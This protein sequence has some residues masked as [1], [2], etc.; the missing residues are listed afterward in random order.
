MAGLF[1]FSISEL[2]DVLIEHRFQRTNMADEGVVGI[3]VNDA[4]A[5]AWG[6]AKKRGIDHAFQRADVPWLALKV[7]Q[8]GDVT[9]DAGAES[10]EADAVFRIVGCE[11]ELDAYIAHRRGYRIQR[12][13]GAG[14][15]D[16]L[17]HVLLA[18][19]A[20]DHFDLHSCGTNAIAKLRCQI[21]L[22]LLGR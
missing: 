12:E 15:L 16:R 1:V 17:D 10:R 18:G 6:E 22:D 19:C 20:I 3:I 4:V 21:P 5:G 13:R 9:D 8:T 14:I 7:A 11:I 2:L